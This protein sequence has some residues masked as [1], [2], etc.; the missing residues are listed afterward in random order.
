[1]EEGKKEGRNIRNEERK[2]Y[3]VE[4]TEGETLREARRK[5]R[6]KMENVFCSVTS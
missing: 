4:G 1:L 3:E 5:E 6:I 2:N